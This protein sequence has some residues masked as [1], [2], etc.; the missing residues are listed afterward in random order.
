VTVETDR[1]RSVNGVVQN[2]RWGLLVL[3]SLFT[4]RLGASTI[5]IQH[6]LWPL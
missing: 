3:A 6:H 5:E 2:Q 1:A 4:S